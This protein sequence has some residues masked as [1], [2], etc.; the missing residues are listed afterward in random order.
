MSGS[1][2]ALKMLMIISL[3]TSRVAVN[4]LVGFGV[5]EVDL[6][7]V[8][9]SV[10]PM[11]FFPPGTP[12]RGEGVWVAWQ[13]AQVKLDSLDVPHC[14]NEVCILRKTN[15]SVKCLERVRGDSSSPTGLHLSLLSQVGW[16]FCS[17]FHEFVLTAGSAAQFGQVS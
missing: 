2:S 10:L 9:W 14:K 4:G 1:A 16:R 5:R 8:T 17:H 7:V 13:A 11:L 12:D 15:V 3:C 6:W